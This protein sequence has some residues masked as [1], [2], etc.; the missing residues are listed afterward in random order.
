MRTLTP[1]QLKLLSHDPFCVVSV[2]TKRDCER[3]QAILKNLRKH[4]LDNGTN[5]S[6]GVIELI[7]ANV[8]DYKKRARQRRR[9]D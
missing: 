7:A 3:A 6:A 9:S 1:A 4:R 2:R 8:R 5:P